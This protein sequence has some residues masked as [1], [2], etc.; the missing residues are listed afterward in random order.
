MNMDTVGVPHA[1]K[2]YDGNHEVMM[3]WRMTVFSCWSWWPLVETAQAT[4]SSGRVA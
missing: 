3:T 2:K 1:T 4:V